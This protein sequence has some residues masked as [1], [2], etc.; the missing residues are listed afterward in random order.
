[1]G[2]VI[3]SPVSQTDIETVHRVPSK[4]SD[5]H[6][7]ARFV[8]RDKKN[9]FVKRDRKARLRVIHLGFSGTN[10]MVVY[11]N[12]HLTMS[13]KMLFAKALALKKAK[14]WQYL[15]SENR[16][17]KARIASD[18]RVFCI[19][20]ESDLRIFTFLA[21]GDTQRSLS[22]SYM[23][24][25]STVSDI[26][27]ETTQ[28]IWETLKKRYVKCP[29]KP[30][31]WRDIARG[32]EQRWNFPN[33]VGSTDG[34]HVTVEAP[35]N[36]G[37]ENFNYKGSFSKILMAVC[38]SAYKFLYVEVG[39]SGGESDGGVFGRSTLCKALETGKLGIPQPTAIPGGHVAPYVILG[40]E[41]FPLKEYLM[42]PYPRR[43]IKTDIHFEGPRRENLQYRYTAY[44]QFVWWVYKRLG[45][46]N[47]VVLPSCAVHRIRKEFPTPGGHYT[48]YLDA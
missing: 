39:R 12:G 13:N 5:Q 38:D 34:K 14:K 3:E 16:Q 2:D 37:S 25:R 26:I 30:E 4:S 46:G 21:S 22:F 43:Y 1:M 9:E 27:S 18:R 20:A 28:V 7:I 45:Q 32:F 11:V 41:A 15:W 24:G 23:I 6:L 19:S 44:R 17:I 31:E 48:G 42:R 40:D 10:D 33:S 8:S 35:C 36:S 29:T 47:R